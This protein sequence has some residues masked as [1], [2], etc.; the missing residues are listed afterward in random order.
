M[1]TEFVFYQHYEESFKE[2]ELGRI[3]SLLPLREMSVKFGLAEENLRRFR[4]KRGRKPYFS[5]EGKVAL[6][7][8]KKYTGL[9]APNLMEA[10]YGDIH[11]QIFCSV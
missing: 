2:S 1:F 6:M 10:L 7:F 5:P 4:A 8:L 3:K 11:Y 9:S